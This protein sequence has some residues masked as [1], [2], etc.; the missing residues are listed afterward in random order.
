M[1][2]APVVHNEIG[3]Q[4]DGP[5]NHGPK[6]PIADAPAFQKGEGQE[7]HPGGKGN[8]QDAA[9]FQANAGGHRFARQGLAGLQ[10]SRND[11]EGRHDENHPP[12]GPLHDKAGKRRPNGEG[13]ALNDEDGGIATGPFAFG[14]VAVDERHGGTHDQTGEKPV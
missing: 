1:R 12:A 5:D 14:H 13:N 11:H 8:Q 4:G 7:E 9:D 2:V 10:V 6:P 3:H